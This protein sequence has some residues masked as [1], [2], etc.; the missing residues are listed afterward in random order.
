MSFLSYANG[1]YVPTE[2]LAL[3][4]ADDTIGTFRGYRIFTACRTVGDKI[5]KFDDHID[6]IF[7][8]A[9][10]VHMEIKES[11]EELTHIV[12]DTVAKN[13]EE[14]GGDFLVEFMYRGGRASGNGVAPAGP[15]DLYVVIFP[16]VL[17]PQE[18]YAHG[19]T[20]AS[21]PYQRQW[22]HL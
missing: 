19:V 17:P 2:K 21:Y 20:L 11:R 13:R 8:S 18:W 16:L 22:Q 1:T 4:V 12:M 9:K 6:R 3:P 7:N 14:H 10:Q 15:A 5:F